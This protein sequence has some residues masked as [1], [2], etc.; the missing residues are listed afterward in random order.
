MNQSKSRVRNRLILDPNAQCIC[1][2]SIQLKSNPN[3]SSA[4]RQS[5][6]IQQ[7]KGRYEFTNTLGAVR[8]DAFGYA[9]GMPGGSGR[10]PTNFR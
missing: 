6:L 1:A 9:A 5:F 4:L 8:I 2:P 7:G 3:I 10:P